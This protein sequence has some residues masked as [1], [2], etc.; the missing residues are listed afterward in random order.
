[1]DAKT[2]R[3]YFQ[4]LVDTLL[5]TMLLPFKKR[6]SRQ[7]IGKA[8]KFYLFDVGIAGFLAGR[9]IPEA[10]GEYFGQALEHFMLM[11]ILAHRSYAELDYPVEFWRTTSGLEVDFVLA[12]GEVAIEVKGSTRVG[13]RDFRPLRAF[14]DEYKPRKALLVCNESERRLV[15]GVLVLPWREFLQLLWAGEI[16]G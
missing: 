10:K 4:I 11:E 8:P 16:V 9:R 15:G 12:G 7:V 1:M 2:V 14:I 6:Q 3:E 5:G 13:A